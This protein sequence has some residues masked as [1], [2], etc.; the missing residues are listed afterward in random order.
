MTPTVRLSVVGSLSAVLMIGVLSSGLAQRGRRRGRNRGAAV[1]AVANALRQKDMA[2]A[3]KLVQTMTRREREVEH[4]MELLRGR[5]RRGFGVGKVPGAIKPD[6][7][8]KMIQMLAKKDLPKEQIKRNANA[9]TEMAY[10]TAAVA[11]IV[12]AMPPRRNRGKRTKARWGNY[13]D[14]M[15]EGSIDLAKAVAAGSSGDLKKAAIR[16]NGNCN[17]CHKIFREEEDDD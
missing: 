9:L 17:S 2:K 11:K 15:Y 13:A 4:F 1:Q 12:E 6:D 5:K 14:S 7:M 10:R 8:E 16:I 3:K